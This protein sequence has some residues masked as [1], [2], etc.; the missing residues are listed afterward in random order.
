MCSGE[1]VPGCCKKLLLLL[2]L[3]LLSFASVAP[4]E[5]TG[6]DTADGSVQ[7]GIIASFI[8]DSALVPVGGD[9][10]LRCRVTRVDGGNFVQLTKSTPYSDR[11]EVLT[12]NMVKERIIETIERYSIVAEPH[13]EGGYDFIFTITGARVEDSGN[14]SCS[15]P[16]LH[17][18]KHVDL[19]VVSPPTSLALYVDGLRVDVRNN[20]LIDY[21]NVTHVDIECVAA[22]GHPEPIVTVTTGTGVAEPSSVDATCRPQPSDL[23]AVLPNVTCSTAVYVDLFPVDRTTSHKRV[24]CSARSRGSPDVRLSASFTPRLT[25]NPPSMKCVRPV[26]SAVGKSA[27]RLVC[28]VTSNHSLTDARITWDAQQHLRPITGPGL[29]PG[30]KYDRDGEYMAYLRQRGNEIVFELEIERVSSQMFRDYTFVVSNAF[31]TGRDTIT[32]V[33]DPTQEALHNIGARSFRDVTTY[34][35]HVIILATTS[36]Y[37]RR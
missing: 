19:S 4:G 36:L 29:P 32:L 17:E 35:A 27:V 11:R 5:R 33:R 9:V 8:V 15:V 18:A 7:K 1:A 12:T 13:G 2:L 28:R 21:D 10:Q 16:M 20:S 3:L 37:Q 23:P 24:T 34:F 25:G 31:G 6:E 30:V 14:Y 22:G 26:T